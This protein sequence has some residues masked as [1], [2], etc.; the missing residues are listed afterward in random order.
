[1][2]DIKKHIMNPEATTPEEQ[3]R[4]LDLTGCRRQGSVM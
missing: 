1:M 4:H 2:T 3:D